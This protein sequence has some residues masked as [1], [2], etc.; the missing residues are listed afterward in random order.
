MKNN[1]T[2]TT[3]AYL[4]AEL[5]R[6]SD[7]NHLLVVLMIILVAAFFLLLAVVWTTNKNFEIKYEKVNPRNPHADPKY[8]DIAGIADPKRLRR[9]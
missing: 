4:D 3:I 6:V 2:E 5:D 1:T 8:S 9:K 7:L